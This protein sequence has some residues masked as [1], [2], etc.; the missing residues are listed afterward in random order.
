V[1]KGNDRISDDDIEAWKLT[2]LLFSV[3]WQHVARARDA[4][5]HGGVCMLPNQQGHR[6]IRVARAGVLKHESKGAKKLQGQK[7]K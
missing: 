5:L 3:V 7:W 6:S 1:V 4:G 2:E